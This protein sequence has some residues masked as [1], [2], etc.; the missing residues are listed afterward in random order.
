[1]GDETLEEMYEN[2]VRQRHELRAENV[3]L[4]AEVERLMENIRKTWAIGTKWGMPGY[5]PCPT[6]IGS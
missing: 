4:K 5:H 2:V 1:M 6:C 3:E